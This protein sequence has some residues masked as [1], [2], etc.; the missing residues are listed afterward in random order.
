M[1]HWRTQPLTGSLFPVVL[2]IKTLFPWGVSPHGIV[3]LGC[4][5]TWHYFLGVFHH[6]TLFLWVFHHRTLFLWVFH[7]RTLFLWVFHHLALLPWVF[8]RRTLLPWMFQHMTLFAQVF[9]HMTLFPWVFQHMTLF[10]QVFQHMTLFPQVFQHMPLFP[11]VFQHMTLFP[12]VFQ[13]V[14][15]DNGSG[16]LHTV[17]SVLRQ[18]QPLE[19]EFLAHYLER[20]WASSLLLQFYTTV[21][22]S[23]PLSKNV[24]LNRSELF[25]ELC[26][27][28][29]IL[30]D[31][32]S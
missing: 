1:K 10:P 21:P 25:Q 3:S 6:R 16:E 24:D 31:A 13:L 22:P 8:H 23:A 7:H 30:L 19:T 2:H 15:L 32:S 27:D 4:F 20:F 9:Q 29:Y 12:W 18:Q 5:T 14:A 28:S 26:L 17:S 11:L